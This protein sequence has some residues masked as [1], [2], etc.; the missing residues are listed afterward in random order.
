MSLKRSHLELNIKAGELFKVGDFVGAAEHYELATRA[1]RNTVPIYLSNLAA[2]YLKL[3]N[4]GMAEAAADAALRLEPRAIK[5]RYRRGMA[6]KNQNLVSLAVIDLSSVL[7]TDPGNV[8]AMAE[9]RSLLAIQNR[10]DIAERELSPEDILK[11]DFPSAYGSSGNPSRPIHPDLHLRGLPAFR[12]IYPSQT[13]N[14]ARF[15][16][17]CQVCKKPMHRRDLKESQKCSRANYCGVT[18]Q[19]ADWPEHKLICN[20]APDHNITFRTGRRLIDHQYFSTHLLLYALRAIGPAILAHEPRD[21]VLMVVVD[22]VPVVSGAPNG[23]KRIAVTNILPVHISILSPD[24][25]DM[26]HSGLRNAHE[27]PLHAV[28]IVTSGIYPENEGTRFR[29][30][31]IV[32]DNFISSSTHLPQF[33]LDLYSH[34][35]SQFH[36]VNLDLD[37]LFESINDELRADDE[38]YYEMQA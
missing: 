38:N 28:W 29:I 27:Y 21:F 30:S 18:C 15:H 14:I 33:S 3:G 16:G 34:S 22:M 11:A 23:R 7:T 19:R 31:L 36:W 20:V 37:L 8:E 35:Y 12:A 13:V 17:L 25:R 24:V 5:A 10:R 2:A 32:A 4:Y 26:L 9:F 1:A 6:R